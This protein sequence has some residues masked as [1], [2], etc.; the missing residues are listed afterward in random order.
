MPSA[1]K[2][3]E[4]KKGDG[5]IGEAFEAHCESQLHAIPGFD[6]LS[7]RRIYPKGSLLFEEGRLARGVHV[8]CSGRAKVSFTSAEGKKLIVRIGQPGDLLGIHS[9]LTGHAYDAT[10]EALAPCRVDFISRK[11]LLDLLDRQK[12]FGLG[13][14]VAI[15]KEFTEFVEHARILL[16]PVSAAARLAGLLLSLADKFGEAKTSGICLQTLLTHEEI[17]QMI[18][19][20]RETVTRTLNVFKQKHVIR[21]TNGD[22]FIRNRAAL[23]ALAQGR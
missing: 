4:S 23:A 19:A 21:V 1:R 2:Q 3:A 10:A 18:G 5:E 20:S 11:D 17:A 9:A 16:L 14:A 8:I 15:S 13:L 22:L 12:L 6:R 7:H